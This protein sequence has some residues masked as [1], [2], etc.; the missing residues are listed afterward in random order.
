MNKTL[1]SLLVLGTSAVLLV[2]TTGTAWAHRG[3]DDSSQSSDDGSGRD[4][5]RSTDDNSTPGDDDG[6]PDQGRGDNGSDDSPSDDSGRDD[7][8]RDDSRDDNNGDD[9][10]GRDRDRRD[11]NRVEVRRSGECSV[12]SQWRIRIKVREDRARIKFQVDSNVVGEEWTYSVS[13]NGTEVLSGSRRTHAPSGDFTV[14][15]K[16]RGGQSGS[17]SVTATA[18]NPQ[19][20]ETCEGA[21]AA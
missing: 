7:S 8:G 6:T 9:S 15:R 12:A 5:D 3:D 11:K 2:P 18:T 13:D 20:G 14:Q 4:R 17:H 1:T 10:R 21:A 16:W 19:T